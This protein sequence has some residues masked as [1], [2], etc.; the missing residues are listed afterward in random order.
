[1]EIT[2]VE[3]RVFHICNYSKLSSCFEF[4]NNE[5]ICSGE[6]VQIGQDL[7]GGYSYQWTATPDHALIKLLPDQQ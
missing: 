2:H 1:M 5:T 7:G 4:V 3:T 6:N